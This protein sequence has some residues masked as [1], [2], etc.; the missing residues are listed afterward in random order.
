MITSEM[1]TKSGES[2]QGSFERKI[3]WGILKNGSMYGDDT[4]TSN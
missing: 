3:L 1:V 2:L 4:T